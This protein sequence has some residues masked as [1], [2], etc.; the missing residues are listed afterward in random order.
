MEAVSMSQNSG[1]MADNLSIFLH[2]H[3]FARDGRQS[4]G[5][6]VENGEWDKRVGGKAFY[7]VMGFF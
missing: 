2:R 1:Y 5:K 3:C 6:D 4:P 7:T